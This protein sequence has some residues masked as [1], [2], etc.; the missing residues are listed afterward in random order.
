MKVVLQ[1]VSKASVKVKNKTIGK[2][3][4]GYVLYV[5]FSKD[6]KE[7]KSEWI[8]KKILSINLFKDGNRLCKNI[9]D[10]KG[11]ILVIS[12]FTL[13][14]NVKSGRSVDFSKSQKYD[15]AKKNYDLFVKNLKKKTDLKVETGIFGENMKIEQTNE[16][17][18]TIII[19]K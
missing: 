8:I 19:E 11:D 3:N 4:K 5:A 16:G 2:I 14:A 6:F 12:Q 10:V 15:L 18:I 17:P 9:L 1:V 7:E 13:F